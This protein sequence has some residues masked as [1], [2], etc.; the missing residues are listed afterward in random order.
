[1]GTSPGDPLA[2]HVYG[3]GIMPILPMLK[4]SETICN[5]KHIAYDDELAGASKLQ[6]SGGIE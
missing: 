5:T 2:M 4:P 3:V 6:L 1:M